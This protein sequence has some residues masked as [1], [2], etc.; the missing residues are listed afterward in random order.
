MP[1]SRWPG[2][3]LIL[4]LSAGLLAAQS[5][6]IR[7]DVKLVQFV[8]TV[9]NRSGDLVSNLQKSDF[10]IFDNG[11]QQEVA[12]L[13]RQT[14]QPLSIALLIDTSGSTNKELKYETDAALK[15][16]HAM[17]AESRPEDAVALFTFN[18]EVTEQ[19]TFTHNL[20]AIEAK[21][22]L[23]HG[24]AGTAVYDAIYYASQALEGR[25]GR[26]VIVVVTDGGDTSSGYTL[27]QALEAAQLADAVAYPVVV[28]PITNDAGRNIGGENALTFLAQGTGGRTFLPTI[29]TAL[30]RA[31]TDILHELRTQYLL[32][33]YPRGVPLTKERFHK[34]EVRVKSPDL[35]V[36]ARNGY[37]G[38][39]EGVS[40]P[41]AHISV[42]PE[43]K[44]RLQ[45]K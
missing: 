11:V 3:L 42:T 8:A 10:E 25:P 23:L 26:K 6:V 32:G 36:S 27:K 33:F 29:G 18:Y 24:E 38:D 22:K 5:D 20:A 21:L 12:V 45:E 35:K 41:G 14:E 4:T 30:D 31:F 40:T 34:L 7:V 19:K 13:N 44:K 39:A 17:F 37:Y 9:K 43:R 2:R 28:L 16:L 1:M 15:F